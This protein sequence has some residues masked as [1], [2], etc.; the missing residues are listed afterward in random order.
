MSRENRARERM[1]SSAVTQGIDR[2]RCFPDGIPRGIAFE[3]ACPASVFKP[4]GLIWRSFDR[5]VVERVENDLEVSPSLLIA[6]REIGPHAAGA[7]ES[8]IA[9]DVQSGF[10][11]RMRTSVPAWPAALR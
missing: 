10:V 11:V 3:L 4:E 5:V 1:R 6:P 7:S 8:N 9:R 2:G